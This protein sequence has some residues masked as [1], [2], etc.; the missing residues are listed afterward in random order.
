[1]NINETNE[2]YARMIKWMNISYFLRL[3]CT[4][5]DIFY[6]N[7]LDASKGRKMLVM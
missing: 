2:H 7:A 5:Y 3:N 1:M 4:N 6:I